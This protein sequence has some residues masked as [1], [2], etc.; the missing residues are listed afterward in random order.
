[1]TQLGSLVCYLL[2]GISTHIF[3]LL[4]LL[5]LCAM[6]FFSCFFCCTISFFFSIFLSYAFLLF[7]SFY[8]EVLYVSSKSEENNDVEAL[9]SATSRAAA[10]ALASCFAPLRLVG[11]RV[12]HRRGRGLAWHHQWYHVV[13][14]V[15]P[16]V[17]LA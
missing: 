8:L 3:V 12:L 17:G 15:V 9:A 14:L 10:T 1:M 5:V 2:L 6:P 7:G 16:L 11:L 13:P 4:L